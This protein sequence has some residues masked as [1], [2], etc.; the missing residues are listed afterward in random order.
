[1]TIE[2]ITKNVYH[3]KSFFYFCYLKAAIV[4][5]LKLV[6]LVLCIV[7][8]S[9]VKPQQTPSVEKHDHPQITLTRFLQ[10]LNMPLIRCTNVFF[11]GRLSRHFTSPT[12]KTRPESWP[13]N[14]WVRQLWSGSWWMS[15]LFHR[16]GSLWLDSAVRYIWW[17]RWDD[18]NCQNGVALPM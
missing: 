6:I 8:N 3:Y 4:F 5:Q 16:W 7:T 1:M 14:T 18:D 12:E 11:Q 17:Q 2:D 13:G 9:R 15:I 10:A